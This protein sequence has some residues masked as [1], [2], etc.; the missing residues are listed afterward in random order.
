MTTT[1]NDLDFILIV[2]SGEVQIARILGNFLMT[3][4]INE[5]VLPFLSNNQ[6]S[7]IYTHFTITQNGKVSEKISLTD[8]AF[9]D[10]F[11]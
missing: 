2:Y 4:P 1:I 7:T 3:Y 9:F 10:K 6:S 5:I 11:S 8:S